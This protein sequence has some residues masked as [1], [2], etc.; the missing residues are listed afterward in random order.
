MTQFQFEILSLP[1]SLI[2]NQ[3]VHQC[4]FILTISLS[5]VTMKE[6]EEEEEVNWRKENLFCS[7]IW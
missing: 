6:E 4:H 2:I 5:F 1:C 7:V 3:L